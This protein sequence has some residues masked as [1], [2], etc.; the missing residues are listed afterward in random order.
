MARRDKALERLSR[1]AR[2]QFGVVTTQQAQV[3]G[4]SRDSLATLVRSRVLVRRF[5]GVYAFR[6]TP[7]SREGRWLAA[8]FA[9]GRRAVLSH[10]TAAAIHG[11]DHGAL[12]GAVHVTVPR[13]SRQPPAGIVVHESP[14]LQVA[15]T[16]RHGVLRVTSVPRTL[17][18]L[19]G[20]INDPDRM[21]GLVA[22]A[23]RSGDTGVEQLREEIERRRAFAG[24]TLLRH[25]VAELSP[26]EPMARAELESL[27]LRITI[28]GGVP[29]TGMNHRVTDADGRTRYLDALWLPQRV[30]A[31]LDSRRFHGT[32]VDWH[33]DQRR[34]NAVL[35]AGYGPCLRFSWWDLR[36]HA[37]TVV[38][39]IRRALA[40]AAATPGSSS[41]RG[42][43]VTE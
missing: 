22:A 39:T 8:Q 25:A 37:A 35:L 12:E 41:G 21:R 29:P 16:M 30:F 36:H 24:R 23:V 7:D 33:D 15:T 28:A 2:R 19:A 27:F 14:H 42:R 34:E 32:L 38:D 43:W 10:R 40:A 26:L 6:G 17:C 5:R 31:E 1:V 11:L 4:M 3:A 18:D 20:D 9:I 13:R